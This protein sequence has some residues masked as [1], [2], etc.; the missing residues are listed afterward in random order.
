MEFTKNNISIY[1]KKDKFEPSQI[2]LERG[3]FII[4]HISDQNNIN[5][6]DEIIKSSKIWANNKFRKCLYNDEI[7]Y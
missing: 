3:W 1:I 2:F 7:E 6:L 4:N 5:N